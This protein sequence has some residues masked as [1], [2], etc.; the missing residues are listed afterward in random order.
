[1]KSEKEMRWA[2]ARESLKRA[3]DNQP[4]RLP[5]YRLILKHLHTNLK[6]QAIKHSKF[7]KTTRKVAVLAILFD[8]CSLMMMM[9][10]MMMLLWIETSWNFLC[11]DVTNI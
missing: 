8:S 3:S 10:M 7:H 4:R 11:P 1:M 6:A 9:M 2:F 5:F